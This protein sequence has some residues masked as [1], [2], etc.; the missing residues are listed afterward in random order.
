[1]KPVVEAQPS[2]PPLPLV[3]VASGLRNSN[4]SGVIW[5]NQQVDALDP[6]LVSDPVGGAPNRGCGKACPALGLD[7]PIPE[8]DPIFAMDSGRLQIA[9]SAAACASI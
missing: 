3:L 6:S 2:D 1:V 5:V 9:Q 4:R 7:C 8:F